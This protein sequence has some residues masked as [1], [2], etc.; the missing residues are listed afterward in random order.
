MLQTALPFLYPYLVAA[1]LEAGVIL[2]CNASSFAQASESG[3]VCVWNLDWSPQF[4]PR[5]ALLKVN[6]S[7]V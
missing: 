4:L 7:A 6:L 1:R 5:I 2:N 3:V